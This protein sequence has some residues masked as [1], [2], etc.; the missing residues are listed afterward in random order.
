MHLL[1]RVF[2][3]VG[4][5]EAV[6]VPQGNAHAFLKEA[7]ITPNGI[8]LEYISDRKK[9]YF[10]PSYSGQI[11]VCEI[12]GQIGLRDPIEYILSNSGMLPV[13]D[14]LTTAMSFA[15]EYLPPRLPV[16]GFT[17]PA[18]IPSSIFG[19]A[20]V[21]VAPFAGQLKNGKYCFGLMSF[22]ADSVQVD[23]NGMYFI[24]YLDSRFS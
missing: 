11:V 21:P 6:I 24:Y 5:T 23:T 22:H 3:E 18:P 15:K 17:E 19:K 13:L 1:R 7:R 16:F 2:T 20:S 14:G 9:C 10:P 12:N 8:I 4:R